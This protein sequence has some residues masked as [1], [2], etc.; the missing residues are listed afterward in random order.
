MSFLGHLDTVVFFITSNLFKVPKRDV[1][2]PQGGRLRRLRLLVLPGKD[3]CRVFEGAKRL[4]R[5]FSR[6][7]SASLPTPRDKDYLGCASG[8]G[9][10]NGADLS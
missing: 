10:R 6:L 4:I 5:L 3:S 8:D 9:E 1:L 2:A 7:R